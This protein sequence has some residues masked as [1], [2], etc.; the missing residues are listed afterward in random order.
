MG[1]QSSNMGQTQIPT[2]DHNVQK[3]VGQNSTIRF[4]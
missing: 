3:K 1:V 4:L 2:S